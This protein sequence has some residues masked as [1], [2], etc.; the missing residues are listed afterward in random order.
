MNIINPLTRYTPNCHSNFDKTKQSNK[1]DRSSS[2]LF[3]HS[4]PIT[5]KLNSPLRLQNM[6]LTSYATM[7]SPTVKLNSGHQMPIVGFG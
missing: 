4:F 7:T 2:I 1:L 3:K 5:R 6:T